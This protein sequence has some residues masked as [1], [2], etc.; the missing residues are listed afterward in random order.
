MYLGNPHLTLSW[1]FQVLFIL[2]TH[3]YCKH[4]WIIESI[5]WKNRCKTCILVMCDHI[6]YWFFLCVSKTLKQCN[7]LTLLISH[8]HVFYVQIIYV[9]CTFAAIGSYA[10]WIYVRHNNSK[11]LYK[12][13]V[14][15]CII[16]KI[17]YNFYNS[18]NFYSGR[19]EFLDSVCLVG[20][21]NHIWNV[22]FFLISHSYCSPNIAL[23][24]IMHTILFKCLNVNFFIYEGFSKTLFMNA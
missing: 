12:F 18:N 10:F 11:F 14:L 6:P 17:R 9:F 2:N 7:F 15:I 22:S 8:N 19:I 16:I 20:R 3:C 4:L 23:C 13:H 24:D 5:V 21:V 1:S